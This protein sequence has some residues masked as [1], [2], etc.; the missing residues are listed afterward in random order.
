MA[1]YAYN[2]KA[3]FDYEI[4]ET[5][6]A[7]LVLSGGEVKSIKGGR[8][9]IE[10]AYIV[11]QK[12]ELFVKGVFIPPYQEKNQGTGYDPYQIRKLLLTKKEIIDI[13]NAQGERGLTC[14]PISMYNDRGYI[15][16]KLAVV[17]GKKK[18]DKRQSIKRRDLERELGRKLK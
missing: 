6:V 3:T 13:Q 2:R 16:C 7:G 1:D 12:G 5:F 17:R 4:V 18:H 8:V 11:A 9:S 15:K 10:G 14:I